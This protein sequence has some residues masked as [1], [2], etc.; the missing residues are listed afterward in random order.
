M[1]NIFRGYNSWSTKKKGFVIAVIAVGL[2]FLVLSLT[3][4]WILISPLFLEGRTLSEDLD[5][6]TVDILKEGE[7][8]RMD[9]IH[10]GEGP[11]RLVQHKD[12]GSYSIYF[13]NVTIANGPGLVVYLTTNG[14]FSGTRDD[15]GDHA[16][17]GDLQAQ[18]G[19]FSMSVPE[20]TDVD[21]YKAVVI[22]CAPFS[23]IFSY[24]D[25]AE[26]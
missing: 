7:L 11:A 4:A 26:V 16:D 13:D 18:I 6:N 1:F 2:I 22:W 24:A 12:S 8:Q 3:I 23:I 20:D 15:I 14:N 9:S 10:Y 19:S 21:Q 25:L 5:Y 17:L